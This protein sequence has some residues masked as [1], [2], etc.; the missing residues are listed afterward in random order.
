[1]K[2]TVAGL[3]YV[4]TS[5]SVL[6]AQNNQVTGFDI[7]EVRVK[8]INN[9]IAPFHDTELEQ[10]MKQSL[11]LIATTDRKAAL[12]N[13]EMVI[14]STPTNYSEENSE[15]D[16][17]SVINV[18]KSCIEYAIEPLIVI[19]STVPVGFTKKLSSE[20]GYGRILFSPEFLRES[21]AVYDNLYPSR[22][23]V[24]SITGNLSDAC[25]FAKLLQEISLNRDV[26][27][28]H[29]STDE[30][31]A[32][33][34]FSNTYL[35]MRVSYFNELD[36]FAEMK[37]L[38]TKKIIDAV[39]ADSR[40]GAFYNNPSFGYGG[41]CL[42]KDT[43]Q[44]YSN[45]ESIPEQMIKATVY[46]NAMRKEYIAKRI[47]GM[48][49]SDNDIVGIY[50]LTMKSGSDNFRESSVWSIMKFL[51]DSNVKVI[52]YEPTVNADSVEGYELV[53]NISEFKEQSDL[54][55]ANRYSGELS[56]VS[57]KVYTRDIYHEC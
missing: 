26:Q 42:P 53:H 8:Q 40:I 46:S 3:G 38:S 18:V 11:N 37:N 19:K 17:T 29:M 13:A 4:G 44:L 22:I 36:A 15:F 21:K 5:L 50:R 33:K 25:I 56:D 24:G 57:Y 48:L 23:V 6:L 41:Y 55:I 34:L 43:K 45:Y 31:E 1:M 52:V 30:A 47:M 32:V 9:R 49:S 10:Y 20:T 28:F 39:C 54:I 16:T 14:I 12:Q 7:S 2:I 27:V 51:S 35:A